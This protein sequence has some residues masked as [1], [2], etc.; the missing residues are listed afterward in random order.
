MRALVVL[1][2]AS[3]A[4]VVVLAGPAGAARS[5]P[6]TKLWSQYPLV[7]RATG[8][9]AVGS[10]AAASVATPPAADVEAAPSGGA[11]STRWALWAA[12]SALT[13]LAVLVVA[14][15]S[16]PLVA[17]TTWRRR[18]RPASVRDRAKPEPVQ[19][20][21]HP[22]PVAEPQAR[23][24]PLAQYAPEPRVAERL[25]EPELPARRSV[26]RRTGILRS[27]FVVVADEG[28]GHVRE[29]GRSKS[30]WRVG[31]EGFREHAAGHAWDELVEDL[32]TSGWEP[33]SER[34]SDFYV[35]LREVEDVRGGASILPT[36]E[37]YTHEAGGSKG[38]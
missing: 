35:L 19:L 37:A 1:L 33:D 29:L 22:Q 21:A 24:A 27:R 17:A 30:F 7:P 13:V 32:R 14:R 18:H 28:D 3:A 9:A 25:L 31:G 34:R 5:H 38:G 36:L 15:V 20:R 6:P 4:A 11:G 8:N 12:V 26:V 2:V 23:G 16:Q 10:S